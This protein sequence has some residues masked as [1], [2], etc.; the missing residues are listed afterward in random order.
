MHG[1]N[2]SPVPGAAPPITPVN[3]HNLGDGYHRVATP[4]A[5]AA[6]LRQLQV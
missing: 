2:G 3:A 6:V 5:A 1:Q 4:P